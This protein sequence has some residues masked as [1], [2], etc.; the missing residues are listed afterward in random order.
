MTNQER[1]DMAADEFY[2]SWNIQRFSCPRCGY[3]EGFP[4]P[5]PHGV[6]E[7]RKCG[8]PGKDFRSLEARRETAL[9]QGICGI[10]ERL[11]EDP[12]R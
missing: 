2:D 4:V 10:C 7:C 6:Y 12:G 3:R 11:A 1:E 5:A 8:W 9:N